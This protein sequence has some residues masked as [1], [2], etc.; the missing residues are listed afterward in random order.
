[1]KKEVLFAIFLGL[2][3]GLIVTF[4][5]YTARN[6]ILH[7]SDE[8]ELTPTATPGTA[9]TDASLS[10]FSPLDESVQFDNKAK[11]TGTTYPNAHVIIFVNNAAQ[12]TTADGSG[13]FSIDITLNAGPNVVTVRALDNNGNQAEQK[14][15]VVLTTPDFGASLV[16]TA[17]ATISAKAK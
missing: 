9:P 6:V 11:V 16:S 14:R 12:I 2:G 7:R 4:G 8:V 15:T 1:M 3:L 13:N 5:I 17:S 10:V